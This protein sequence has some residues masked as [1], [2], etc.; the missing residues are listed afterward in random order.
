MDVKNR[1]KEMRGKLGL[2]GN[3]LSKISGVAQSTIS[4]IESGK[5]TP[6]VD[7]L[8]RICSAMKITIGEFF[9]EDTGELTP[10]N[11]RLVEATANLDDLQR[12]M[13]TD[14]LETFNK[15]GVA[16]INKEI[17]KLASTEKE[18]LPT[19]DN[20]A[21]HLEEEYGLYD[22]ELATEILS[23]LVRKRERYKDLVNK[24]GTLKR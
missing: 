12:K 15:K 17:R 1:L 6:S 5:M 9:A 23:S 8:E 4:D 16:N 7:T 10:D 18:S 21:A 14:F 13:L 3:K 24:K 2:S 20:I 19:V 22:E 11:R